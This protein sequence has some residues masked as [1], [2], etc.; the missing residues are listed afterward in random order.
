MIDVARHFLP[1]N[2][3]LRY[4]D[5]IAMHKLNVLHL[6]LSDNQGGGSKANAG[7]GSTRWPGWGPETMRWASPRC[8]H[9]W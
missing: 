7:P 8:D 4:I 6:H 5:L 1:V 9:G 3:V 2:Q